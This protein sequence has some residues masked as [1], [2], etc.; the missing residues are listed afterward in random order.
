MGGEASGSGGQPALSMMGDPEVYMLVG[1][2]TEGGEKMAH[3]A[4]KTEE[5]GKLSM[6]PMVESSWRSKEYSTLVEEI[7]SLVGKFAGM[8]STTSG[9]FAP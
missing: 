6:H 8:L 5:K 7:V 9:V 2:D 1:E 3:V 4:N